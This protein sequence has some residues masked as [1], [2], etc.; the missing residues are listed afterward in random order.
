MLRL[1]LFGT[2]DRPVTLREFGEGITLLEHAL[3]AAYASYTRGNGDAERVQ[4]QVVALG[5]D[6]VEVNVTPVPPLP[7]TVT[8]VLGM[9]D[10]LEGLEGGTGV[11][12]WNAEVLERLQTW[13]GH[14]A[15]RS[16]RWRLGWEDRSTEVSGAAAEFLRTHRPP[17]AKELLGLTGRLEM[18]NLHCQW[19]AA[20]YADGTGQ[21]IPCEFSP[22]LLPALLQ[23]LGQRVFAEGVA[24]WA[25]RRRTTLSRLMLETVRPF[26]F[27]PASPTPVADGPQED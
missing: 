8:T 2:P 14:A 5:V 11:P 19:A 1:Q 12:P 16:W 20:L 17:L 24:V 27:L 22:D 21:R 4:W 18:V 10:A 23:V 25:D 15:H 7:E 26:P 13:L 9:I 6:P 3:H